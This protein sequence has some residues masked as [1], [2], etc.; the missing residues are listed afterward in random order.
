MISCSWH[1][2]ISHNRVSTWNKHY[3]KECFKSTKFRHTFQVNYFMASTLLLS[4]SFPFASHWWGLSP[5]VL[6]VFEVELKWLCQS[7]DGMVALLSTWAGFKLTSLWGWGHVLW[8]CNGA[9]PPPLLSSC[10]H[11]QQSEQKGV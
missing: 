3:S 8:Q 10:R 6:S 11:H 9:A 4:F 5:A 2:L 1:Q 7:W